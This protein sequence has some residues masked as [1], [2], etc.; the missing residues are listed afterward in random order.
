QLYFLLPNLGNVY[1]TTN[2]SLTNTEKLLYLFNEPTE[3]IDEPDAKE[4]VV[5]NG[6]VEF[7]THPTPFHH[8]HTLP[9]DKSGAGKSTILHVPYDLQPS[10]G[11]IIIDSQNICTVMLSSI[12]RTISIV[13]K[14]PI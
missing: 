1:Y 7:G 14:D 12:R 4:L 13:L 11:H 10:L 2:Q 8:K 6:E 3:V 5:S 9:F